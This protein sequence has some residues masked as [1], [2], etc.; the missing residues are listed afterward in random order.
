MMK[1]ENIIGRANVDDT[2]ELRPTT[3]ASKANR[4]ARW[5]IAND[6]EPGSRSRVVPILWK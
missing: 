3:A 6:I 2:P 5:N 1:R 4:S